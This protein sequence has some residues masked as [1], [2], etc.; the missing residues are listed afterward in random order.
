MHDGSGLGLPLVSAF[1]EKQGL[2][3]Q[4]NSSPGHGTQISITVPVALVCDSVDE[5]VSGMLI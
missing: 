3:L 2:D 1:C 4:I 5:V